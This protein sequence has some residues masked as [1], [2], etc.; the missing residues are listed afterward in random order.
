M[1]LLFAEPA[2][3]LGSWFRAQEEVSAAAQVGAVAQP[4]RSGREPRG[5]LRAAAAAEGRRGDDVAMTA[6]VNEWRN[7]PMHTHTRPLPAGGPGA[8]RPLPQAQQRP[9]EGRTC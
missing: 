6:P 7:P 3:P 5:L 1:L 8:G 4:R 9:P 2:L